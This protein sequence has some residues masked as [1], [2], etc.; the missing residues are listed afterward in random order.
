MRANYPEPERLPYG[1][2]EGSW[3]DRVT[4]HQTMP[5]QEE[6]TYCLADVDDDGEEELLIARNGIIRRA[7]KQGDTYTLDPF[8]FNLGHLDRI[9]SVDYGVEDSIMS[10]NSMRFYEGGKAVY[11]FQRQDCTEYVISSATGGEKER[12]VV[13]EQPGDPTAYFL[14]D[15]GVDT[16]DPNL[17]G[18]SRGEKTPIS[19]EEYAAY[20]PDPPELEFQWL[21][22]SDYPME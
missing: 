6:M 20:F 4:Y 3:A 18:N 2:A 7:Y 5:H 22:L 10:P 21:P 19:Q 9:V 11:E 8:F 15:Y 16:W 14:T 17:G 13:I 12:A 1:A